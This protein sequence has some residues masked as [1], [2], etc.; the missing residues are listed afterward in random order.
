M[1]NFHTSKEKVL[2]L[3]H[4]CRCPKCEN[5]CKFGSGALAKG[6]LKRLAKFLGL[7][8]KQTKKKYLE[9]IKKFN[10]TLLRPKILRQ[11][12]K[13]YGK[14]IFYE[15]EIGCKVHKAKPTECKVAMGCK[16]YGKELITWF[17]LR[18]YL[19]PDDPESLRE[20]K[21]YV[22][23]G[24]HVLEGAELEKFK[25][26]EKYDDVK[27]NRKKD[28][29]EVLGIKEIMNEEKNGKSE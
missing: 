14:C 6:D 1:I 11:N 20:Y 24:G 13:P 28:W 9:E 2:S 5:P 18:N 23:S 4:P 21:I 10:T 3:G 29:D 15:P 26:D 22:E 12:D 17:H 19:N 7:S 25:V 8:E 16:D 27:K